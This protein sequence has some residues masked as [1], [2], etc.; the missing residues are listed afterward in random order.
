MRSSVRGP[1]YLS[2]LEI[3]Y[4]LENRYPFPDTGNVDVKDEDAICVVHRTPDTAVIATL[5]HVLQPPAYNDQRRG[6]RILPAPAVGGP[7]T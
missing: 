6:T 1:G 3:H 4:T 5:Y 7:W 2:Q